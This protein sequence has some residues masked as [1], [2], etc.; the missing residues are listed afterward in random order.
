MSNAG[1]PRPDMT[2]EM[3]ACSGAM[4]A[5]TRGV[6]AFASDTAPRRA[7]ASV[8][9]GR[10]RRTACG[11]RARGCEIDEGTAAEYLWRSTIDV[12]L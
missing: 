2:S 6:P 9:A 5:T 4:L 7:S 12:M 3:S 8:S 1:L 10:D 11:P